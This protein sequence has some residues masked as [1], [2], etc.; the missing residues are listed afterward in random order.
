VDQI[1]ITERRKW[2]QWLADNHG[3]SRGV[4]L[5]FCNKQSK[6]PTLDYEA[7][8]EEALCF[9]WIDSIIKKLD[10]QRYAR[11]FTPRTPQSRWSALNKRR[12]AK[13]IK[14]GVMMPQGLDLVEAANESGAWDAPGG[15]PAL[16]D[17]PEELARA[18]ARNRKAAAAFN[19]LAPTYRKH[20]IYWVG[21]AKKPE[22]RARRVSESV[23]LLEQG[24]KLGLK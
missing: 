18:L 23:A 3:T 13:L 24:R 10:E 9:G 21:T 17:V 15:P 5:V 8:V 4:W 22:T 19:A 1:V 7:A 6:R 14:Q 20:F 2:R 16:V 12:V 11:K